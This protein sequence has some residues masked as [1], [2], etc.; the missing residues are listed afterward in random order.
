MSRLTITLSEARYRALKSDL[1][2]VTGEKLLLRD[3]GMRG[4]VIA[5]QMFL[6]SWIGSAR[7]IS[8]ACAASH[9]PAVVRPAQPS[10]LRS[11]FRVQRPQFCDVAIRTGLWHGSKGLQRLIVLACGS[12]PCPRRRLPS[13]TSAPLASARQIG[14]AHV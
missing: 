1:L 11:D 14:R 9:K 6:Q 3:A 10:S 8:R 7:A 4:R 12:R 5:P 2:L 13:P